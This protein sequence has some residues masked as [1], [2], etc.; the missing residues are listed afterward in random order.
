MSE[1]AEQILALAK[2]EGILRTRDVDIAGAPRAL[3]A[4]LADDG[5]LLKLGRGLYTLPDRAAS[6]HESFAEVAARSE[7]GVLCLLSALRFHDPT[8]QQS[9]DIWLAIPHKAR[10]P[11]FDYPPL[12][13]IRMSGLAMTEGVE[14]VDV[15]GV[16]VRV[17]SVAKTVADSFKFRNKIGLDVALEALRGAWND[18]RATMDDLWRYAEMCRVANVVRPYVETVGAV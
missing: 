2:S 6:E 3:L 7:S 4:S 17:F 5:R 9:P 10:A 18:K 12:R 15:G 13:I 16:Q 14:I 11:L 1:T 8:T